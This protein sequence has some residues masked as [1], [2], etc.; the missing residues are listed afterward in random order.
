MN[1]IRCAGSEHATRAGKQNAVI[2][3]AGV[4]G[5]AGCMIGAARAGEANL[6][7]QQNYMGLV[8]YTFRI[9]HYYQYFVAR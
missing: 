4:L 7:Q 8:S 2:L 6:P 1:R 9:R 3:F 5:L